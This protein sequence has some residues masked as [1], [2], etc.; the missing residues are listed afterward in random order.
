MA[1]MAGVEAVD[2]AD[3][4]SVATFVDPAEV[5]QVPADPARLVRRSADRPA[6]V[7]N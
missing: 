5:R 6:G 4:F 3:R 1:A 7:L 2:V